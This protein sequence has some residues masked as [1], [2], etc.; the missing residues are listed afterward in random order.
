MYKRQEFD[1]RYNLANP[2]IVMIND[3]EDVP[4]LGR[5][6]ITDDVYGDSLD[7]LIKE[8]KVTPEIIEK[9]RHNLI[10]AIDYIPVSYTHLTIK[11][12]PSVRR[13]EERWIFPYQENADAL[14]NSSL[15]FEL[16]VMKDFA[17]DILRGVPHDVPEFAEA[18]RL[19]RLLQYFIPITDRLIP[20]TSLRCV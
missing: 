11:R 5:C 4:G 6:I 3:F 14:F 19:R 8:N 18:D 12:W 9:L 20:H 13:G 16:G 2:H 1:V 15:I 17:E 7:K 10:D